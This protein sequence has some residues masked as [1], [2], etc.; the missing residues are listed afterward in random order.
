MLLGSRT[1]LASLCRRLAATVSLLFDV[2]D[3]TNEFT[4]STQEQTRTVEVYDPA[5]CCS[6][7]VCGPS[8]DP[9]LA[10]FAGDADWLQ[11][12]GVEVRRYNLAQE[13]GA[14]A[15]REAVTTA[16]RERGETCLPLLFVD[17]ELVAEGAY[18]S[19]DELAK[20]VGLEDGAELGPVWGPAVKELV[21]IAA[22][23]G[24]NCEQC[25]E[26]HVTVAREL[27][28]AQDDL[29]RAVRTAKAVKDT[30]ARSIAERADILLG[31]AEEPRSGGGCCS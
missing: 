12:Q 25:L 4:M 8:V 13:P 9:A 17:G 21:A 15:G 2:Q 28:V 14:F 24:S 27:G 1:A 31:I 30:P 18:P 22:A 11:A 29:A 19:R 10:A 7:G 20:L 3:P 6:T 16:L 26:H 23:V 5:L